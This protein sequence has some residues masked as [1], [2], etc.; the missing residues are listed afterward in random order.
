[1]GDPLHGPKT[2]K[3]KEAVLSM[4]RGQHMN[5]NAI[6]PWE[7]CRRDIVGRRERWGAGHMKPQ[8]RPG[9]QG[10]R[11]RP[12]HVEHLNSRLAASF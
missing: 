1:M 7:R 12:K 4:G 8:L 5:V 3:M 11:V 9:H 2:A 10:L 6:T